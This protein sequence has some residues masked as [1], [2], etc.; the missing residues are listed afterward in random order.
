[1][2]GQT[3]VALLTMTAMQTC[4]LSLEAQVAEPPVAASA[5]PLL[6]PWSGS[7]GGLPPF[8]RFKVADFEPAFEAAMLENL[9]EVEVIAKNPE[10]PTFANTV[11]ALE[12]SGQKLSRV[13]TLY[14]VMSTTMSTPELQEV[15]RRLAA[16]LAGHGDKIV[17]NE[18][19][20][21]RLE[22]LDQ[23]PEKAGLKAE[24]KRLLW[25][26][27]STFARAG[28]RLDTNAKAR[29]SAINQALAN[30]FTNFSQNVL[31]DENDLF[32]TL[33]SEADL[34]GL[35][36]SVK[37][38]AQ[39]AARE[40]GQA[41]K[42]LIANTR[43]AIEP[44]LTYA[45]RRDLREKSWSMFTRRGDGG[46]H[47]NNAL[48]A[49]I[50][51][52][53]AERAKLLG[54]ATHAHW[55][56]ENTMAKTPDRT[57]ELMEAVWQP[58]LAQVQG[59]VADMA[60]L[61]KAEGA[62]ITIEPWDYRFY[63]EKVRKAR[64]DFDENALKPYLQ[65][66]KLREGMFFVAG[67]LFDF[68]FEQLSGI[69]VYH[70]D[71]TVYEVKSKSTGAHVGLWFFDPFARAGK[72]SGAWM[73][74]Y[75][76]QERLDGDVKPIVSNNSNFIAG[77]PGEPVLISWRDAKTLF[78]EFGHALHGLS[79]N[80]TYAALAGTNVA[81]D[82]VEFPSQLLEHWIQTPEVLRRFAVHYKTGEPMPQDLVDRLERAANFN[83]GFR[84]VEYL[85]GAL[86]DMRIHLADA[87]TIDP[88]AFERDFAKA[89]KMPREIVLRHRPTHFNHVFGSDGYSA[90]YYS[91]LWS[92]VLTADAWEAFQEAGGAW[93]REVA[94]R[95]VENVFRV[96]N[97][98]EPAEAYRKF[99]GRD[100]KTE[101]LMRK[102][103]LVAP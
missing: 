70:P 21:R 61:A 98:L 24:Q 30:A 10:A 79:S 62:E 101:A 71:V 32:L 56:L 17:Q 43:S 39:A 57:L 13:R 37:S 95:L 48:I 51:K 46:A 5:N 52:L 90:G 20:F 42:W 41:G 47:D 4:T 2:K 69:P 78:H 16:K 77:S 93:D 85:S 58:A 8:G 76:D 23:G 29:L 103:G 99:R 28:A 26:Q 92:D 84:T 63:S 33:E 9:A 35:P 102:R 96:G 40:K 80:V 73:N 7:Y 36:E 11:E 22:A 89:A 12:R 53:R 100:P 50:L 81:R 66:D 34:L 72:R 18:A 82:Y 49:E 15:E 94:K 19:L 25:L 1:M 64:Y 83:E 45:E 54:F 74:E 67:E 68:T 27:H 3:L 65:L 87:L 31:A 55:R 91:Y 6:A 44:F 59:E 97:T 60:A 75:R 88:P 38:A 86:Y 14:S